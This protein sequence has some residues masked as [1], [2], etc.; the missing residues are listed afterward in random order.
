MI[1]ALQGFWFSLLRVGLDMLEAP[2]KPAS[3]SPA[4]PSLAHPSPMSPHLSPA[5][6]TP[7]RPS[8]PCTPT[9]TQTHTHSHSHTQMHI[10]T[11]TGAHTHTT[12]GLHVPPGWLQHPHLLREVTGPH[13]TE[14]PERDAPRALC[15]TN[16]H[17]SP[18]TLCGVLV[19]ITEVDPSFSPHL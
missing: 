8:L 4:H 19:A 18:A 9:Y 2:E 3:H 12:W 16:F 6:P 15:S 11:Y 17:L 7:G 5:R 1:R 14:H 10:H 13:L